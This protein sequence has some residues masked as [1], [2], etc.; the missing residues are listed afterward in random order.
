VTKP[1]LRERLR[2]K[3]LVLGSWVTLAH[4]AIAEIL[5]AAGFDWLAVDLEHSVI[6]I[7]EAEELIRVIELAGTTPLVR[8]TSNDANLIKRI[9]DAGAHGIIVPMINTAQD[10]DRAVAAVAGPFPPT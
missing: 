8:L 6:T 2:K 9:M 4:P 10:A 5:C 3:E 1:T 7:G